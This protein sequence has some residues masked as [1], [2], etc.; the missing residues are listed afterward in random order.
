MVANTETMN[1]VCMKSMIALFDVKTTINRLNAA[2]S[3]A[4]VRVIRMAI[5]T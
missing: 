3:T 5:S 1:A 2:N 4:N